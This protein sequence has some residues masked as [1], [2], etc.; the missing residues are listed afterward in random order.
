[1]KHFITKMSATFNLRKN[2]PG[3]VVIVLKVSRSTESVSFVY[4]MLD[5]ICK[6]H[7]LIRDV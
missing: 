2:L 7:D 6:I 3:I 1:M 4:F 5:L